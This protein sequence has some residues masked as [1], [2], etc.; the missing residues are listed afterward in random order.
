MAFA[1]LA[2]A[3]VLQVLATGRAANAKCDTPYLRQ[4]AGA[5]QAAAKTFEV[6][7]DIIV[8]VIY[9]ESKF[10][11]YTVGTFHE[12]GLMQIKRRGAIQGDW[13]KFSDHDLSDITLNIWLGTAYLS[14]LKKR[15]KIPIR[16]LTPFNGGR[17]VPSNYS[18][19][20]LKDLR[21][22]KKSAK[23]ATYR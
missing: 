20:V 22:A 3:C 2:F 16:Y 13:M 15:C 4:I 8:A 21:A 1:D 14:H 5:A 18:R 23:S 10:R 12:L 11:Q 17:C 7:A 6:P 9:R 19:G